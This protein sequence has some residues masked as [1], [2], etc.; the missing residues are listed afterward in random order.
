MYRALIV[1]NHLYEA[2]DPKLPPLRGPEADAEMLGGA[3]VDPA[4]GLFTSAHVRVLLNASSLEIQEAASTFS[5]LAQP[6][7]KLLFYFSGHGLK[8]NGRL[9]LCADN[10]RSTHLAATAV[11]NG[12]LDD[13]IDDSKADAK[14]LILDC[15]YSGAF[16]GDEETELLLWG[17]GR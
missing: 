7:E 9:Y 16:K 12:T 4:T 15:C 14:I 5:G 6:G 13:I 1:C 17:E 3:L 8:K 2:R 10:T 11:S